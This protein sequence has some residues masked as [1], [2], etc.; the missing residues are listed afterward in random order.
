VEAH[1]LGHA[2]VDHL[3]HVDARRIEGTVGSRREQEDALQLGRLSEAARLEHRLERRH[4]RAQGHESGT[5]NLSA[6]V[7]ALL[8]DLGHHHGHF[9][10]A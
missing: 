8:A 1:A 5:G 6:D 9:G 4:L 2:R 3:L 10:V 7:N